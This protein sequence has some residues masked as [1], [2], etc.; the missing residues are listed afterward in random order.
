MSGVRRASKPRVMIVT[1]GPAQAPLILKARALGCEVL[2]TDINGA[3]PGLALA[4]RCAIADSSDRSDL[5][6]VASRFKP[7]AILTEQTD[8][9]VASVAFVAAELGLPGIGHEAA[10]RATDKWHLR[11]ACRRAGIAG[12]RYRLATSQDEAVATAE[13]IGLPVIVK[14]ADN[15]ASRGVT[16]VYEPPDL[17]AAAQRALAASRSGRI[18]VEELLTGSECSVESFVNDGR[19][20]VLAI[21]E[22]TMCKPPYSYGLRQIYPAT[23]PEATLAEI[24]RLNEAVIRTVGISMG[25][26]HAEMIVTPAG[27]RII[28]IAARGCGVRVATQLLPQMTGID[29][30]ALR[31]RQALGEAVAIPEASEHQAGMFRFFELPEGTVHRIEGIGQAAELD[32]VIHLEFGTPLGGRVV[33]PVNADERPGFVLAVAPTRSA[34]IALTEKV[35]RLVKIEV[36]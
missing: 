18:M 32:G 16:K 28:E 1:A 20:H 5:L 33:T 19:V 21:G 3:A 31:L 29:L 17:A 2:A 4:D 6:R 13:E 8:V 27:V 10:L 30:L 12:P 22:K 25:F 34:V 26:S 23:F 7:Q 36:A 24:R 11:E 15:Q 9:A 14:P 35:M